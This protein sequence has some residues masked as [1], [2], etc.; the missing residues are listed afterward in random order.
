MRLLK[1]A[2]NFFIL[3]QTGDIGDYHSRNRLFLL[4][5]FYRVI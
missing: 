3:R 5:S 1:V 2:R 4:S